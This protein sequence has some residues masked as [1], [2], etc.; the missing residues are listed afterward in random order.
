MIE[1]NDAEHDRAVVDL[2]APTCTQWQMCSCDTCSFFRG[3][4]FG[5]AANRHRIDLICER[6]EELAV[7]VRAGRATVA[8]I[9]NAQGGSLHVPRT[10]L[11]GV[12]VATLTS[13][14]VEDGGLLFTV[15]ETP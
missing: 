2:G 14:T 5:L 3:Y 13:V 9:V 11:E 12:D 6:R 4:E 7:Q 10:A 8:A 15:E 1:S